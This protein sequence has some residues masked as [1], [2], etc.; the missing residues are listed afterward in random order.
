MKKIDIDPVTRL[1]GHGKISIFLDEEGEVENAYLQVPEFRGFEKFCEDRPIEEVPRITPRI[2]GVCPTA[3]HMAGTKAVD[4]VYNAT[5]PPAAEKIRE[6]VYNAYMFGD[7][8]LHFYYLGGPDFVVGPTAPPE[9]RNI[10]G[11][12]D[13]VGVDVGKEVIKHRKYGQ[14]AIEMILGRPI[15]PV[16]GVAGGLSKTLSEEDRKE[17]V[18]MAESAVE[19]G[20]FTLEVFDD[21]VLSN[22]DYV[23][24]ITSEGYTLKTHY[25]GLVDEDN[26]V[27]YYDGKVRVVDIEG[28]EICKYSPSNYLDHIAEHV[29]PWTYL[30]FP[31]LKEKGWKGFETGM[32][33]GIYRAAPL[34]RLNA[35]DGMSTPLAQEEYEKMYDTL[36]GKPVHNTLAFHWARVIE[37]MNAAEV[38]LEMAQDESISDTDVR[39]VPEESPSEGVGIVE[40][41]RGTLTHHY[42]ADKEGVTQNVNLIVATVNNNAAI[43]M[44]LKDAAQQVIS[45]GEVD[46]GNLNM[47]EMAYR[48]YDPCFA[49]GTHTLG[50]EMNTE[51]EIHDSKGELKETYNTADYK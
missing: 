38:W 34:G 6:M 47:I 11:V 24:L 10:L 1:E 45:E 35:A 19:F 39:N 25:M 21:V 36:G 16:G 23:D 41:P 8:L 22:T 26:R 42:K 14:N 43:C 15:H 50:K 2:C 17:L 12:I 48:A 44:G 30:K 49:C 7:H 4:A 9:E 51:I 40:A 20:K 28:N 27:N 31:Y 46:E 29:E 18:E 32:D 3:H 37:L 5:L 13:E 33:S